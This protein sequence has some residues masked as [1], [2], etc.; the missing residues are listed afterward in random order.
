MKP[1]I[2]PGPSQPTMTNSWR[3]SALVFCARGRGFRSVGRITS[4][5]KQRPPNPSSPDMPPDEFSVAGL[6]VVELDPGNVGDQRLQKRFA[7][8]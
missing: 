8:D 7:L 3:L 4:S 5:W 2:L 1:A 6:V